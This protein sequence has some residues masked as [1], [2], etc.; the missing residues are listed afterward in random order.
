MLVRYP[1][2]ELR[3]LGAD[4]RG[5][6]KEPVPSAHASTTDLRLLPATEHP[7][8]AGLKSEGGDAR[9]GGGGSGSWADP[10]SPPPS[11]LELPSTV[12]GPC[13]AGRG[14]R[15]RCHPPAGAGVAPPTGA[16]VRLPPG[17]VGRS[18]RACG[19]GREP[20]RRPPPGGKGRGR[21]QGPDPATDL[22]DRASVSG[23]ARQDASYGL[24]R[25][26]LSASPIDPDRGPEALPGGTLRVRLGDQQRAGEIPDVLDSGGLSEGGAL[27]RVFEGR[28]RNPLRG[29]HVPADTFRGPEVG[30]PTPGGPRAVARN[31]S[32]PTS[33]SGM[34][35]WSR[36]SNP[37]SSN[38]RR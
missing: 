15:G 35:V 22:G 4:Q 9:H 6:T 23:R 37:T 2:Q 17:H 16:R 5:L 26:P 30:G 14:P 10:L 36:I 12:H 11:S 25:L 18:G 24:D 20:T 33:P 32:C 7:T 19:T 27:A 34:S 31:S 29:V 3:R 1:P 21:D 28:A 38:H 8:R 13:P